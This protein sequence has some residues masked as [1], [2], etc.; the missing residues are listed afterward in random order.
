M[1]HD[2]RSCK[3][4]RKFAKEKDKTVLKPA[5][6]WL[7]SQPNVPSVMAGATKPERVEQNVVAAGSKLSGEELTAV[8]TITKGK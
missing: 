2:G 1:R 6:G 7:A 3:V 4:W 8:D 5:I